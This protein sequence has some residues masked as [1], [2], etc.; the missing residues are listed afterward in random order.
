MWRVSPLVVVLLLGAAGPAAAQQTAANGVIAGSGTSY[1]LTITN[2][3]Q[4]TLQCMRFQ[5][6]QGVQMTSASGPGNTQLAGNTIFGQNQ[7]IPPDGSA[8]W[9]FQTQQPYPPNGGGN[10]AVSPDCSQDVPAGVTGPAPPPPPGPQPSVGR[11][12]V[13]QR[14][15]GVVLVRR[16]G[17][18]R[19]VRVTDATAIPDGSEIDTTRGTLR[20]TVAN[21]SGG[22]EVAD[23]SEGRAI[24]D[25]DTAARPLTTLRLSEPLTCPRRPSRPRAAAAQRRRGKKK[26]RIFVRTQG[27]NFR[28]K[29][30]YAAAAASGTAWRT[31]DECTQTTIQVVEGRVTVVSSRGLTATVDAPRRVIVRRRR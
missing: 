1:T 4:T 24:V 21:G 30:R 18:R 8:Q 22:T 2:T 28:T 16:R 31:T 19:F 25:Q 3:G 26:R 20:L 29:G 10:L 9:T 11:T 13:V 23:V 14:I 12:E 5:P 6:A 17:S 7:S 27:G 15:A